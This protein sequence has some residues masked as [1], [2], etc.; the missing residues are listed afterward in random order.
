MRPTNHRFRARLVI[1]LVGLG[2]AAAPAAAIAGLPNAVIGT[3]KMAAYNVTALVNAR[4]RTVYISMADR[5]GQSSCSGD[6]LISWT[7]VLTGSKVFARK[8]SGVNQKLLGTTRR[9]NGKLQATY[10]HH[11]LY[12][13]TSD[14]GPGDTSGQ[15]CTDSWWIINS[16]GNAVNTFVNCQA[17]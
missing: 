3:G 14:T 4:G 9:K 8:G 13:S 6:C 12:T 15:G 2:F 11:P 10:N 17:Y 16:R 5:T 1:G 7:P